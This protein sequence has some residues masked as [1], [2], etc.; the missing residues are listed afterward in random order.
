MNPDRGQMVYDSAKRSVGRVM[1]AEGPF[2]QLRS[3]AGLAWDAERKNLSPAVS[4]D[5]LAAADQV[6]LTAFEL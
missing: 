6:D 1:D 5:E 3:R 4:V 2:V